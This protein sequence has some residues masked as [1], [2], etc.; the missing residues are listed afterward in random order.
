M[1]LDRE[2]TIYVGVGVFLF[3]VLVCSTRKVQLKEVYSESANKS[4]DNSKLPFSLKP[5]YRLA[6]GEPLPKTTAKKA[7][8]ES[9]LGLNTIF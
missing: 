3:L 8:L 7:K 6:E 4:F 1:S 9:F 5:P 2:Q